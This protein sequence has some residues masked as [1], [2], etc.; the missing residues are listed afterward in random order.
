M[1]QAVQVLG[2]GEELLQHGAGD[3]HA[4]GLAEGETHHSTVEGSEKGQR[5]EKKMTEAGK[6]TEMMTSGMTLFLCVF[7]RRFLTDDSFT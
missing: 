2:K 1:R 6:V 4:G 5:G 7:F 3:V